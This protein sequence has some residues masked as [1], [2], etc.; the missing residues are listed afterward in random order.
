MLGLWASSPP[1]LPTEPMEPLQQ[2]LLCTLLLSLMELTLQPPWIV[3][4]LK[5]ESHQSQKFQ[6]M[7]Q[8]FMVPVAPTQRLAPRRRPRRLRQLPA[9]SP[10]LPRRVLP[11]PIPVRYPIVH[12]SNILTD[13]LLVE[14]ISGDGGWTAAVAK[15]KVFVGKLTIDEKVNLTTGVDTI[16]RL[17]I[18]K[19]F[20]ER[21]ADNNNNYN[22]QMRWQYRSCDT[23]QL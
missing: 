20:V 1:G 7:T 9:L 18:H 3:L 16:G 14:P 23:S 12:M 13:T 21:H 6:A 17:V 8:A 5:T 10:L 4:H 11:C 19:Q 15:A 22:I 2:A